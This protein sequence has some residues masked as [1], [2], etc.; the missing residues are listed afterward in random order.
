MVLSRHTLAVVLYYGLKETSMLAVPGWSRSRAWV[1]LALVLV[2]LSMCLPRGASG[3]TGAPTSPPAPAAAAA[4][5]PD[6]APTLE[7]LRDQGLALQTETARLAKDLELSNRE[8][9]VEA[10][11]REIG[12]FWPMLAAA[13]LVVGALFGAIGTWAWMRRTLASRAEELVDREISRR[14]G[15]IDPT[16]T[17]V[18]LPRNMGPHQGLIGDLLTRLGFSRQRFYDQGQLLAEGL[19]ALK[20]LADA[21]C[22]ILYA[23][24]SEQEP[25]KWREEDAFLAMVVK[26]PPAPDHLGYL[27]YTDGRVHIGPRVLE[28]YPLITY[29][30]MPTTVGTNLMT[31][32]R[33]VSGRTGS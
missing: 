13:V 29:S 5:T 33:S 15:E 1:R 31:L 4:A 26:N 23:V 7:A 18:F 8:L 16:D 9:A 10:R 3:Q 27:I 25:G 19:G 14:W 28:A 22:V 12:D 20:G 30:N 21:N 11:A 17:A 32:A 24:G 2:A 6:F